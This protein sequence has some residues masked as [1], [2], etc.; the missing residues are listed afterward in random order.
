MK[1]SKSV[2]A[3]IEGYA[4]AGGLEMVIWCDLRVVEEDAMLGVFCRRFGV[5][6]VDGGTV[7][8]PRLIGLSHA[9]YLIL[10]GRPG[11]TNRFSLSRC[12]Q[13]AGFSA[14]PRV[15]VE[16]MWFP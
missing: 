3:A 2:I 11:L 16:P 4:G 14:S 8:L 7:R 10:T 6:L 5:P 1:L 12:N 15:S 9:M 13:R